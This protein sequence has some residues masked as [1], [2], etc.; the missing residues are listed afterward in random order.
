MSKLM[1]LEM[2]FEAIKEGRLA[3]DTT[4]SVSQRAYEMGGSR[5]F[6]EMRDRPTAKDLIRGIAVLS[7]NDRRGWSWPKGWPG[8]RTPMPAWGHSSARANWA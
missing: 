6:L 8:Q 7:G 3:L 2:L 1:T 4:F 5:M